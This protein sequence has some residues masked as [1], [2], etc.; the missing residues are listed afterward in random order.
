M[1]RLVQ[2]DEVARVAAFL[3]S[4]AASGMTGTCVAADG[5][6]VAAI[7]AGAAISYTGESRP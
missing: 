3:A 1:G 2:P 7:N 6:L 5:G 4:D